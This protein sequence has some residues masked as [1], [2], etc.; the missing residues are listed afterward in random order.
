MSKVKIKNIEKVANNVVRLKLEK[1]EGIPYE[2]GQ[3]TDITLDVSPW[4]EEY[5]TFTFT[6][7]PEEDFLEF[8]I[9]VYEDHKGVT[10]QIGKLKTGDTINIYDVYGDINYKGEGVFIAG[11]AGITPFIS[12]IRDL[13]N[14]NKIGDNKLIFAN[15][16]KEDIIDFEYFHNLLGDNFINVLSDEKIEEFENG[17][18][19]KELIK[20]KLDNDNS[21]VYLCGPPPMMEAVLK[22]LDELGI[23]ES[24]IVREGF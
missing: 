7:L 20:S 6:S 11:G 15:N 10:Q 9:K 24:R 17:Y 4:E 22:Q 2:P 3:A 23:D 21:F 19:T 5:R 14:K 1:P 8:T 12:I 18:I 13:E 16:K